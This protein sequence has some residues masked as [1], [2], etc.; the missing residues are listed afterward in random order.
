VIVGSP[1][2]VAAE[3]RRWQETADIDGFNLSYGV[4]SGSRED[5][6]ELALPV[7]REEVLARDVYDEQSATLRESFYGVGQRYTL[8][9]HPASRIRAAA[10]GA[11]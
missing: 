11:A 5:F 7:L 10:A 8:D 9:D 2:T 1:Q 4:K 6:I 3:M